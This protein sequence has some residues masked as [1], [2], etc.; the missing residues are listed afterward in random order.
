[1]VDGWVG[2]VMNLNEILSIVD[3]T[4]VLLPHRENTVVNIGPTKSLNDL[5]LLAI[6]K[7]VGF[8][9]DVAPGR[10]NI[11]ANEDD[12]KEPSKQLLKSSIIQLGTYYLTARK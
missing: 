4:L 6:S 12:A 2:L 1:M 9:L 3:I 11:F 7:E 10:I 8:G 5:A